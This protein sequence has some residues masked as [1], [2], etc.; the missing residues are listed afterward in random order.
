MVT[1]SDAGGVLTSRVELVSTTGFHFDE[2]RSLINMELH[3]G[4]PPLR[5]GA[6]ARKRF[7]ANLEVG[8][9][10]GVWARD[11]CRGD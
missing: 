10:G 5:R 9:P 11:P 4:T 3:L 8:F 2:V 6:H 1:P 7:A